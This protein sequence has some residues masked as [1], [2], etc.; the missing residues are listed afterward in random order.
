MNPANELIKV[1]HSW[2]S[3][4]VCIRLLNKGN[5]GIVFKF[6]ILEITQQNVL[7]RKLLF[8]NYLVE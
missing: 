1:I 3:A 8:S 4:I 2:L 7:Y 6:V 5:S